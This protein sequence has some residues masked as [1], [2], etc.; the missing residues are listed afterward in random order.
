MHYFTVLKKI[1]RGFYLCVYTLLLLKGLKMID[2]KFP[3]TKLG[4]LSP[5]S[6]VFI[7][8]FIFKICKIFIK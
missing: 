6:V 3:G 5:Y 2:D 4:T 8:L 7:I 1:A